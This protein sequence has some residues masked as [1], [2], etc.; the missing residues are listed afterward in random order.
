MEHCSTTVYR[1]GDYGLPLN[2]VGAYRPPESKHPPYDM[3]LTRMTKENKEKGITTLIVGDLNVTSWKNHYQDWIEQN[4]LWELSNPRVPTFKKGTTPDAMVMA[5]GGYL[6][7]G[8]MTLDENDDRE[9][10]ILEYYP[11]YVTDRPI[12]GDHMALFL[13]FITEW[14]EHWNKSYKYQLNK[15]TKTDWRLRNELLAIRD[16]V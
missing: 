8:I 11:A 15:L 16:I 1:K 3:A 4:E 5:V 6:P 13:T 7:E 14:K 12:L 9:E 2:I 10:E